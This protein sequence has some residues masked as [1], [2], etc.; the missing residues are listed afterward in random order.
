MSSLATDIFPLIAPIRPNWSPSNT[1][2]QQFTDGI[3]SMIFGLFDNSN[4]SEALVIKIFGL[5]I[6]EFI[7]R[8]AEVKIMSTLA[9][10]K[11]AQ[12]V[13]LRFNNGIIYKFTLGEICTRDDIR[14]MPIV[15]LIARQM[16]KLHS[17]PI[18]DINQKSCLV[19]L[20]RKF[21]TLVDNDIDRPQGK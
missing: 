4:Q 9:E 18:K 10:Y 7:D 5:N 12:P 14:N 19:P 3:T 8:G 11:L 16:A 15:S 6:E 20:T 1:H 17:L 2:L 21:L 13:L